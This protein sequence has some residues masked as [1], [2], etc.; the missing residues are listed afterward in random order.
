MRRKVRGTALKP[1]L[2]VVRS[3]KHLFVQLIDDE[4]GCTLAGMGT[5]GKNSPLGKKSKEAAKQL[6]AK[7]AEM[8]KAKEIRTAVFDRGY[9][10]FHGL[11]AEIAKGARES[12]LHV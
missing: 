6:G 12:G 9:Y 5:M 4:N 10:K 1:R 7:I 11:I 2:S 8:A 3:N